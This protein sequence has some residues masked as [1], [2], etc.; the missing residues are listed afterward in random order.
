ML[1][2]VSLLLILS[3]LLFH[4]SGSYSAGPTA[5]VC[6]A[7]QNPREAED[8]ARALLGQSRQQVE[9]TLSSQCVLYRILQQGEAVTADYRAE[10][11]NLAFDS[12]DKL[13]RVSMF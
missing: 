4:S 2:F 8:I 7:Y 3:I 13:I 10:R 6:T 5:K 9:D 12:R 11:A 1:A